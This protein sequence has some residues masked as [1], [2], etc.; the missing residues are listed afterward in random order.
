VS[1]LPGWELPGARLLQDELGLTRGDLP[2]P[3]QEDNPPYIIGYRLRSATDE[4]DRYHLSLQYLAR[5]LVEVLRPLADGEEVNRSSAEALQASGTRVDVFAARY[6]EKH[7][8]LLCAISDYRCLRDATQNPAPAPASAA[9]QQATITNPAPHH[10]SARPPHPSGAQLTALQAIQ[11][12]GVFRVEGRDGTP[13]IDTGTP[14]VRISRATFRAL[15]AQGWA[16]H[17]ATLLHRGQAVSLTPEGERVLAAARDG[18]PRVR[19]AR[20]RSA[21]PAAPG[22]VPSAAP[23]PAGA[24]PAGRRNERHHP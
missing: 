7:Y 15:E 23:P 20:A 11:R 13:R 5:K 14:S 1:L 2:G 9:E 10:Q 17:D 8:E 12:G 16:R 6:S 21:Q 24:S 19:A 4:V 22:T 3:V 18:E